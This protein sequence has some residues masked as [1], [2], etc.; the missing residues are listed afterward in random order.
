[1]DQIRGFKLHLRLQS[2]VFQVEDD[3][4]TVAGMN[5]RS[6]SIS[7][8]APNVTRRPSIVNRFSFAV[9]SEQAEEGGHGAPAEHQIE[10]EIAE[11]KRY[12]VCDSRCAGR[13]A[14]ASRSSY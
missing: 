3:G 4:G 11:I 12:E 9:G 14:H 2:P 10:E 1:M 6:S 5:S 8:V 7:S 13:T